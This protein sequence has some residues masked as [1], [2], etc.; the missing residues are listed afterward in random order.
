MLIDD[1]ITNLSA[2]KC[3]LQDIY[4]VLTVPSGERALQLLEKIKP[5]L[6]LL[7]IEMPEM[8]GYETIRQ[9]KANHD[10]DNIP[11]IFLTA[12]SDP[13]SEFD[14]LSLGAVDYISKP[15]S[16]PLLKKRIELHMLIEEQQKRLAVQNERLMD[17][18]DNLQKMVE[19]KTEKIV[20]LQDVILGTVADLVEF[21]DGDTGG[22]VER[23][24]LYLKALV[25]KMLERKIYH[26]V[27]KNWDIKLV[28]QSAQLHDVGKIGVPDSILNKP[29]RLDPEEFEVM[30]R[31]TTIGK[32]VIDRICAKADENEFLQQA[33]I[34]AYS[35]HERWDGKGYP[36]GIAAEEIPLQGRM[37]AI[38]DVYDALISERPYK[39]AFTHEEAVKIIIDGKGTQFDPILTDLFSDINIDFFTISKEIK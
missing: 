27:V 20:K 6:I 38:A 32:E 36:C 39:K 15:F 9:I 22:H 4:D 26:D 1:N 7:D 5:D 17:Y 19:D 10:L 2:G 28:I 23:T 30:K 18:N 14:G 35:H 31:H 3:A 34:L 11:V 8:D 21:R 25:E 37:M 24:Q 16:V 13:V 33:A 12:K 29:G